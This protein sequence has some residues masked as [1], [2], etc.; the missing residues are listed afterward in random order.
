MIRRGF[1]L[2]IIAVAFVFLF[3]QIA[4]RTIQTASYV[5]SNGSIHLVT[6]RTVYLVARAQSSPTA[7]KTVLMTKTPTRISSTATWAETPIL[8]SRPTASVTPANRP[9]S[10]PPP[11]P[12]H[13]G[14]DAVQIEPGS[15]ILDDYHS[16]IRMIF[17]EPMDRS[18]VREALTFNPAIN[19]ATNWLDDQTL[20]IIPTEFFQ[21][22][23]YTLWLQN[24]IKTIDG[25]PLD[26]AFPYYR[27]YRFQPILTNYSVPQSWDPD[28]PITL[29]FVEAMDIESVEAAL[30]IDL[31]WEGEWHWNQAQTVAMFHSDTP[32]P[33]N[34]WHTLRFDASHLPLRTR[35]D[36]PVPSPDAISFQT[37]GL[38][39][40]AQPMGSHIDPISEMRIR[41]ARSMDHTS[42]EASLHIT[43]ARTVA[44]EWQ[45][46][47][48]LVQPEEAYWD[49]RPLYT[50][51]IEPS[52]LDAEKSTLFAGPYIWSFRTG[53]FRTVPNFG[54]GPNI[55]VVDAMGRRAL[56]SQVLHDGT[57]NLT[58]KLYELSLD[59]FLV[60]FQEHLRPLYEDNHE[61]I[62]PYSLPLVTQ[63]QHRSIRYSD[64]QQNLNQPDSIGETLLSAEIEPGLYVLNLIAGQ[65]N[66]QLLVLLTHN[67]VM[68]KQTENQL[69]AWI[70]DIN[71]QPLAKS[72]VYVY[73]YGE[74]LKQGRSGADGVFRPRQTL[75]RKRTTSCVCR[76]FIHWRLYGFRSH[77][78][79]V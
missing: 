53:A 25:L 20:E 47:T 62:E 27:E 77:A 39:V 9:T 2:T 4:T 54:L 36:R 34:T 74:L 10:A 52:A 75:A 17:K 12:Q 69:V 31:S 71:D 57:V 45:S 48:P 1:I 58:F 32:P 73:G 35:A 13:G 18:S 64:G 5:P 66:D 19:F 24:S 78:R 79:L 6:P 70:T 42:V 30:Q 14:T 22:G 40:S 15:S 50:V 49:E 63:W 28:D 26:P 16:T 51:T 11:F 43:P 29:T 55:Q 59:Q 38:I 8:P 23:T 65:V 46:N 7:T 33:L 76:Q 37:T 67:V 41:F 56:Q 61:P 21:P 60:A 68:V 72:D 3:I 44:F